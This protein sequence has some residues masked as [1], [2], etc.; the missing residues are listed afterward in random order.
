MFRKGVLTTEIDVIVAYLFDLR[1]KIDLLIEIALTTLVIWDIGKGFIDFEVLSVYFLSVDDQTLFDQIETYLRWT[2]F[3]LFE[4]FLL[5]FVFLSH[6]LSTYLVAPT[7]NFGILCCFSSIIICP[8][9]KIE[10]FFLIVSSSVDIESWVFISGS[11]AFNK[12][13]W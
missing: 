10:S 7:R 4:C 2:E 12:A 3:P 13:S 8:V 9:C 6:Q 11:L 5:K 1:Q